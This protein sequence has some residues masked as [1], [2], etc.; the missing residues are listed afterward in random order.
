MTDAKRPG[1]GRAKL[2]GI[3]AIIGALIG[4]AAVYVTRSGDGNGMGDAA[5]AGAPALAAK[6]DP[7]ATG[8]VAA[9]RPVERGVL[10]AELAFAG[11]DGEALTVASFSG[12]TVLLNLWATWC[13]PCRK[14]MPAL[15]RLEAAMGGEKFAV[16]AVNVD[17]GNPERAQRFLDEIQVTQLPWYA[18]PSL[19]VFN[20]MKSR[21]LALGLPTTLLIDG[22]GCQLGVLA[23]PAEWDSEDARLLVSAAI[24]GS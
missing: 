5:C 3:A 2:I 17:T 21:G 9:F 19:K 14:E 1:T 15:D 20:E 10:L 6:L 7:L 16:V 18:D 8:E 22:K 4:I 11:P 12:R 13:A 23:G 24:A